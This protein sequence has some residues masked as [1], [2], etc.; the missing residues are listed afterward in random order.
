DEPPGHLRDGGAVRDGVDA[1][2]DDARGLEKDAGAWLADYQAR[3][4]AEHDLPSLKV[5]YN[6]VFGYYIELPAAQARRAPDAFTR[7]QTLKNAERYVTP[8]LKT[9]EDKVTTASARALERERIIFDGLCERAR[10]R[11]PDLGAYA[12]TVAELD[13]LLGFADKAHQRGWVRPQIV[14][15]RVLSIHAGRHPVLDE[16]L[17]QGFVPNDCELGVEEAPAG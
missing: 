3:L 10:Q 14:T 6:S 2:L 9:F 13:V 16:T 11:V 15:D 5:G 7:K 1:E 12:D 8:E 17:G 4:I